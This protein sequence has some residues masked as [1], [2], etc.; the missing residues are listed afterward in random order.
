MKSPNPKRIP[1]EGGPSLAQTPF[2]QLS[3]DGFPT[4]SEKV[5]V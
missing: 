3:S 1:T 2:A 4:E 5:L